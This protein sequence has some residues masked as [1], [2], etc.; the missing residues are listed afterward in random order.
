MKRQ[1][2]LWILSLLMTLLSL[3]ISFYS[4]KYALMPTIKYVA[5]H[6]IGTED[7]NWK[8]LPILKFSLSML[9]VSLTSVIGADIYRG[10]LSYSVEEEM[11]V[12][13]NQIPSGCSG[14]K[15]LQGEV[16]NE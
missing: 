14:C 4:A 16:Y 8:S 2:K 13:L 11:A 1:Q 3:G 5:Q 10:I 15:H 12:S 7:F 9:G 6:K